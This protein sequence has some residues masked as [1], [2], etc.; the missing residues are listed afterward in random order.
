MHRMLGNDTFQACSERT[1]ILS[2][3]AICAKQKITIY[4]PGS[5]EKPQE[6]AGDTQLLFKTALTFHK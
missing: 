1:T 3:P 6:N 2:S 4:T 5:P